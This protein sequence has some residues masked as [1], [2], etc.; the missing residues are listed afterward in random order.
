MNER[1]ILQGKIDAAGSA[2]KQWTEAFYGTVDAQKR[3]PSTL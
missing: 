3:L 1:P 2:F